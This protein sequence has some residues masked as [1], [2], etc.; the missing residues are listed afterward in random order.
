MDTGRPLAEALG[1]EL[2]RAAWLG[3]GSDLFET[4]GEL[5]GHEEEVVAAVTHGDVL[6]AML[7]W[8]SQGGVDL[9]PRPKAPKGSTWVLDWPDP[10]AEGVPLRAVL[11]PP[12]A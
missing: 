5:R 4:L 8:L 3:E 9:G 7:E 2:S 6:W 11:L 10:S 12:P 1:L